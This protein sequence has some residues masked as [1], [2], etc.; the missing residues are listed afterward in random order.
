MIL[1]EA[2]SLMRDGKIAVDARGVP[3]CVLVVSGFKPD[4]AVAFFQSRIKEKWRSTDAL[5]WD[6]WREATLEELATI[7]EGPL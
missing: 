7:E 5:C 1:P 4:R 6:G 2:I 3:H